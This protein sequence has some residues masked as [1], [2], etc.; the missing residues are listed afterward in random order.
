MRDALRAY[1]GLT[2][3]KRRDGAA[4]LHTEKRLFGT[5]SVT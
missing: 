4:N 2:T 3:A 5:A 1:L